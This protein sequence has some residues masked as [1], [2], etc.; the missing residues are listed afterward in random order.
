[1][2][3]EKKLHMIYDSD[4]FADECLHTHTK[5]G[6]IT[7]AKY[8][9]H[10]INPF[11]MASHIQ[12]MCTM[13]IVHEIGIEKTP[14]IPH[15]HKDSGANFSVMWIEYEKERRKSRKKN[16]TNVQRMTRK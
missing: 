4:G 6:S 14:C 8:T 2:K 16:R 12:W 15:W 9:I 13:Y 7:K 3:G 10:H 1:M 5:M 11:E